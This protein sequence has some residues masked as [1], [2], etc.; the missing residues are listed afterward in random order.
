MADCI[1]F[2]GS[3]SNEPLEDVVFSYSENDYSISSSLETGGLLLQISTLSLYFD[4]RNRMLRSIHGYWP[5]K[6]WRETQL[7]SVSANRGHVALVIDDALIPPI[8]A[9]LDYCQDA[10][11]W[12]TAFDP[13]TGRLRL[14]KGAPSNAGWWHVSSR[15]FAHIGLASNL[16]AIQ[17]ERLDI[18]S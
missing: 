3:P 17:I 18:R 16:D 12:L 14:Q 11:Q 5:K 7:T 10:S 2:I 15:I 1:K 9:A 4:R 6:N 8:G 13:G